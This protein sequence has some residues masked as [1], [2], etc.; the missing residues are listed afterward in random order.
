MQEHLDKS[1]NMIFYTQV[2]PSMI[3]GYHGSYFYYGFGDEVAVRSIMNALAHHLE[4]KGDLEGIEHIRNAKIHFRLDVTRQ[5][6]ATILE[7]D[8]ASVEPEC[9]L[10]AIV[11]YHEEDGSKKVRYLT[12]ELY[13]DG[14]YGLCE[15]T[16]GKHLNYGSKYGNIVSVDDMWHAVL[17]VIPEIS[18]H[19]E[20]LLGWHYHEAHHITSLV[21]IRLD[22][23][24]SIKRY[25]KQYDQEP[26][27][28]TGD[29]GVHY[30]MLHSKVPEGGFM[31]FRKGED[32]SFI[33]AT[34]EDRKI[35]LSLGN[36][37]VGA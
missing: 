14:S 28:Y 26:R 25:L 3:Q 32:G 24:S 22:I 13:Y 8:G 1:A 15:M 11:Y 27:V 16:G 34:L 33:S 5:L 18:L 35:A 10:L 7:L 9:N 19:P 17:N 20:S 30:Y 23:P 6:R 12:S 2:L 37:P 4:Q 21:D 36:K 31:L 29:N